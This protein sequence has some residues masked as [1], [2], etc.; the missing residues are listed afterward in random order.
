LKAKSV[1]SASLQFDVGETVYNINFLNLVPGTLFP[2]PLRQELK[3]FLADRFPAVKAA[4]MMPL[5]LGCVDVDLVGIRHWRVKRGGMWI[6]AQKELPKR[7]QPGDCVM[8]RY[9][10]FAWIFF[11]L[12][13]EV[14]GIHYTVFFVR[15]F[16]SAPPPARSDSWSLAQQVTAPPVAY[17]GEDVDLKVVKLFSVQAR[18]M[19]IEDDIVEQVYMSPIWSDDYEALCAVSDEQKLYLVYRIVEFLALTLRLRGASLEMTLCYK[20]CWTFLNPPSL[21]CCV[22]VFSPVTT[23][24]WTEGKWFSYLGENHFHVGENIF[25]MET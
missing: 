23:F 8:L 17:R 25:P 1:C 21:H 9:I 12:E 7:H 20:S 10:T 22:C 19:C 14:A 6:R 15:H 24:L 11:I 3:S 13:V 16:E 18:L 4:L 2:L 5:Y